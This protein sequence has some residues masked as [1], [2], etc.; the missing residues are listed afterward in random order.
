MTPGKSFTRRGVIGILSVGSAASSV[1]AASAQSALAALAPSGPG[2]DD[3]AFEKALTST[4]TLSLQPG[5]T[6]TITR[7]IVL[8]PKAIIEGNGATIETR[9]GDDH[10]R[11]LFSN[12]KTNDQSTNVRAANFN[13]VGNCV[14]FDMRFTKD[15]PSAGLA[16]VIDNVSFNTNDGQRRAGT[17]F[18]VCD[19]VDFSTVSNVR[20]VNCDLGLQIGAAAGRRPC[21]QLLLQQVMISQVNSAGRF[22]GVDK[23][24]LQNV[25]AM[26]CNSGFSF[27]GDNQR[28]TVVDGHVEG[29]AATAAYAAPSARVNPK[30]AGCGYYIRD[31]SRAEIVFDHCSVI[32]LGGQNGSAVAGVYIGECTYPALQSIAFQRCTFPKKMADSTTYR[33]V[34][35]R[36]KFTWEGEWPYTTEPSLSANGFHYIDMVI[37]DEVSN[38][39]PSDNLLMGQGVVSLLSPITKT[40][41]M[42]TITEVGDDGQEHSGWTVS[43]NSVYELAQIVKIPAGW[44]T[45]D[46]SGYG[47]AGSPILYVQRLDGD[48]PRDFVR[49]QFN[50]DGRERRWRISFWN[51]IAGQGVK[52]GFT[53]QRAQPG[54][55]R[56]YMSEMAL[57]RG[58]ALENIPRR[59]V[60]TVAVLPRPSARW[61]GRQVLLREAGKPDQVYICTETNPGAAVWRV[62]ARP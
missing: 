29:I 59:A 6:Y 57:Y 46:V 40:G 55:D 12:N 7:T 15:R 37:R 22:Q 3:A 27:E 47:L 30:A 18:L 34:V 43:F 1:G 51:P 26:K 36:G 56:F 54:A 25:D 4:G 2:G 39:P 61:V 41:A 58:F 45:I 32:D 19:Q 60:E 48:G 62:N 23:M 11:P 38:I 35:N 20:I 42:P 14:V 8:P 31:N 5:Q 10:N 21:T 17:S 9:F 16:F 53:N 13:V 24:V 50:G 28:T 44:N 49:V 33:P 52:V